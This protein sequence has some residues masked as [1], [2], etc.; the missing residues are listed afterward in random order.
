MTIAITRAV[1]PAMN[2]CELTCIGRS[3]IDI[4]R[5][6]RQHSAYLDALRSLGCETIEL[7]ADPA[8]PDSVFVEDAALVL[9]DIAVLCRPGA[10]SRRAEVEAIAEALSGYRELARIEPPG[11]LDGGDLLR[12]SKTIYAGLSTRSNAAGVGQL[13]RLVAAHGY[14]LRRVP[15]SGCLHLKSAVSLAAPGTLLINPDWVDPS[16]FSGFD[17]VEVDP[18]EP[19][20]ANVL[21]VNGSV[22]VPAAFP[23]TIGTLRK[24][25]IT[26]LPVDVSELQKAEGGVTCC[27]LILS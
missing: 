19:H 1:S 15:V 6:T 10:A 7:P 4:A 11:T 18:A 24:H 25:G 20:A 9:D 27:S 21:R 17:L 23:R 14:G 22:I 2:E 26:V 16:L 3:G 12:V 8:L 13:E 5:A